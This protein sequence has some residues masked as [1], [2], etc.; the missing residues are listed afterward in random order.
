[1]SSCHWD[2][3]MYLPQNIWCSKL[4]HMNFHF[5]H[6]NQQYVKTE[7]LGLERWLHG[8]G[9]CS[10][11]MRN[12]IWLRSKSWVQLQHV[13]MTSVFLQQDGWRRETCR[14]TWGS[15]PGIHSSK[16]AC[17]RQGGRKVRTDARVVFSQQACHGTVRHTYTHI[18]V[19]TCA[20]TNTHT[21]R[22]ER[23]EDWDWDSF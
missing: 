10:A 17:L 15:Q 13:P 23:E 11:T 9:T 4:I 3:A 5:Y 21:E 18:H 22:R 6:S 8:S 14:S 20:H 2:F 16:R 12:C 1:M 19:C 7:D